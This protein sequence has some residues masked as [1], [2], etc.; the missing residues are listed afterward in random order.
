[1]K[2]YYYK[3]EKIKIP[4]T[5]KEFLEKNADCNQINSSEK[6]IIDIK[7]VYRELAEITGKFVDDLTG[8][9]YVINSDFN[10]K[11]LNVGYLH[12][13][14]SSIDSI[15]KYFCDVILGKEGPYKNWEEK[16]YF[17]TFICEEKYIEFRSDYEIEF[18]EIV[19]KG[20]NI[21][22]DNIPLDI[23]TREKALYRLFLNHPEGIKLPEIRTK[24]KEEYSTIYRNIST[25]KDR[26]KT[27]EKLFDSSKFSRT[28]QELKTRINSKIEKMCK[29]SDFYKIGEN[30]DNHFVKII[31]LYPKIF[32]QK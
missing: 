25:R 16:V 20:E 30:N 8:F 24:H 23:K 2:K 17:Q 13:I 12:N 28:I 3:S 9:I 10:I 6:V 14:S 32:S 27:L 22:I 11:A 31:S 21:E 5:L 1:M 7:I 19:I 29:Y 4:P 15:Q 18:P 26:E